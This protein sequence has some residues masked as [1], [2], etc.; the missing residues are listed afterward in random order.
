MP[1]VWYVALDEDENQR[2]DMPWH[3]AK[4]NEDRAQ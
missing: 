2:Y 3:V 1:L 4:L